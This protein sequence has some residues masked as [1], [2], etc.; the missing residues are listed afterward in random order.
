VHPSTIRNEKNNGN[1]SPLLENLK[2]R[3]HYEKIALDG[4]IILKWILG[5]QGW[6]VRTGFFKIRIRTGGE[7]L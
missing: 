2:E 4:R 1:K 6:R 7:L 5:K 3:D